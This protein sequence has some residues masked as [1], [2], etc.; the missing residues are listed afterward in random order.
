MVNF[1]VF[2]H[3]KGMLSAISSLT[4][5]LKR[6]SGDYAAG[7]EKFFAVLQAFVDEQRLDLSSD[8][9]VESQKLMT[10][11]GKSVPG[12]SPRKQRDAFAA[13]CVER[14]QQ[15]VKE[16]L[17]KYDKTFSDC[18]AMCRQI[19]AQIAVLSGAAEGTLSLDAVM[20]EAKTNDSLKPYYA[21]L[22]GAVGLYNLRA[23]FDNA[24]TEAGIIK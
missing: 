9:A 20:C 4:P 16:Y 21:Q 14:V 18:A 3:L 22:V 7:A 24:L 17:D 10:F 19:G 5:L 1:A 23:V 13:G 15:K 12:K 11:D 6:S 2:L 8:I